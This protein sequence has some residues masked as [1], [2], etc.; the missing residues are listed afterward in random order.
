MAFHI[1]CLDSFLDFE[2]P[3]AKVGLKKQKSGLLHNLDLIDPFFHQLL[4]E[5]F[6]LLVDVDDEDVAFLISGVELLLLVV[7]AHTCEDCLIWVR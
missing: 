5:Q 4:V 7:P 1:M 2:G 6:V 3:D